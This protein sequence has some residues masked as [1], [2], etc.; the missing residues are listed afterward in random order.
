M[1]KK[2]LVVGNND[3]KKNQEPFSAESSDGK[4]VGKLK[5]TEMRFV[6][7]PKTARNSELG[8]DGVVDLTIKETVLMA[9]QESG[10]STCKGDIGGNDTFNDTGNYPE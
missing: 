10:K 6:D 8:S 2:D 9:A 5:S 1:A 7:H 3:A 4:N